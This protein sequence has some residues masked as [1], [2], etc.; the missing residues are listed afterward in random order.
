MM[1]LA[2]FRSQSGSAR[3][4]SAVV[5]KAS[6]HPSGSQGTRE[7]DGDADLHSTRKIVLSRRTRQSDDNEVSAVHRST[8]HH[9]NCKR[10]AGP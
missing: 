6:R 1:R 10:L 8:P 4:R 3:T 9:I 2:T 7:T 5:V